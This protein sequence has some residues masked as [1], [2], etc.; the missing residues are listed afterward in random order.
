MN[1]FPFPTLLT[2][3]QSPFST[4]CHH[5]RKVLHHLFFRPSFISFYQYRM[6]SFE[7]VDWWWKNIFNF[8]F[9]I[10]LYRHR[11]RRQKLILSEFFVV[12]TWTHLEIVGQC[13]RLFLECVFHLFYIYFTI[14]QTCNCKKKQIIWIIWWNYLKNSN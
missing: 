3:L 4:F 9:D 8:L 14:L 10:S 1:V 7:R 12:G 6:T 5:N 11:A 2:E 13:S